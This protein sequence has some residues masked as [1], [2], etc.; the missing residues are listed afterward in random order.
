MEEDEFFEN[1]MAMDSV[2]ANAIED[3]DED[4]YS[5]PLAGT[6]V[7]LVQEHYSKASTSRETE[8]KRWIQA[9][10][11]YRGL[12]G[13]DVQF[14]STEKSRVFVKVTK[15]KVLAAY[16][17][18]VDVLFGNS[19]FPIT[20]DPT[21]LPEGVADSVFFESNDDMRKAKEE[22]GGEDMQLRPG[23]TVIDLQERLSGSKSKLAPVADILEEGNGKTATEITIHPA[24]I[25]NP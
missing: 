24:M 6:I 5:D 17:Q 19:K 12:Y 11:N 20:V 2:E 9:Y 8:E 21:T 14:T 13:P 23:E 18:I 15:T 25:S 1:E 16:G 22:F 10:R 3:M 4:N 7:G